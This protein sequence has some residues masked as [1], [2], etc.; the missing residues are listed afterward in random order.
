M[1]VSE[2]QEVDI[3]EVPYDAI[4]VRFD[5]LLIEYCDELEIR[6]DGDTSTPPKDDPAIRMKTCPTVGLF[7]GPARTMVGP[8]K[9]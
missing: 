8:S 7:A 9:E 3:V 2:I 5:M 1:E 6:I 4:N